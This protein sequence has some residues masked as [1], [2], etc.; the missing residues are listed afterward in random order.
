LLA[1]PL[2]AIYT[3]YLSSKCAPKIRKKEEDNFEQL[4]LPGDIS[5]SDI[6][7]QEQEPFELERKPSKA[8][9]GPVKDDDDVFSE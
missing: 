9:F 7:I 3:K 8:F 2:S 4:Y 5:I 6:K 1:G